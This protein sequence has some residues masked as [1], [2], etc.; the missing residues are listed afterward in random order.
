[1]RV[2]LFGV[3]TLS[4][5]RAIAAQ[6]R[7][8]C[9]V[10]I[11]KEQD[12]TTHALTSR[13][14]LTPFATP[15]G[16]PCRGMR[17]VNSLPV[18]LMFTVHSNTLY[19]VTKAGVVAVIGNLFTNSG[20]VSLADDGTYLVLVDGSFGYVYNMNAMGPLT[21]IT[22][23]NFTN[24]PATVTWQD[25]YFIVTAKNNRQFQLSQISPS[26]NPLVWPAVQIGFA[27]SGSGSLQAGIV[28][29]SILNLFGDTY[30]EFWQDAGSPDL[31]YTLLQ[32]AS[33]EYG[34]AAPFSL[35]RFDNSII[36]L[37]KSKE[38]GLNISRLSGF[39]LKKVSDHDVD[40]IIA[41]Y[42]TVSDAQGISY[43]FAG[44]PVYIINFPTVGASWMYDGFS[45]TWSQLLTGSGRYIGAKGA[46]LGNT[47]YVS[48]YLNGNIYAID[49]NNFTD[50]GAILPMEV[51]TKHIWNDDK[52]IGINQ[53]QV[54]IESGVGLVTGQ[55]VNPVC[56]LQVSKDGGASFYSAG[57]SSM[58]T[59]GNYV[60][61]MKWNSL[62]AARDWVL[63]LRITD[64][65]KRVIT[66]ASAEIIG[67]GF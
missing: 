50:N 55:G 19:S 42:A 8:N 44:H 34:L 25:N 62:G 9:Q 60:T 5:S 12:R 17:A 11:R 63:K 40:E 26:I 36:G 24:S 22:D 21:T 1:M 7:I 53:M 2:D 49:S 65:V 51:W 18:Q 67:G 58:G 27:G 45:N 23:G 32:G 33:Q 41:V 46:T 39:S 4:E 28:S 10:E 47:S 56:D 52:Y 20:D 37:F 64:P 59:I 14:G 43:N 31:P 30:S 57:F 6:K 35:S 38:G 16:N 48:D 54:D 61:R 29:H 3:G 15:D 66:G 13:A